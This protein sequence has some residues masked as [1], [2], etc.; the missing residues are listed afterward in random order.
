MSR[1]E[2]I[3]IQ[4][5][6]IADMNLVEHRDRLLTDHVMVDRLTGRPL[7]RGQLFDLHA[8]HLVVLDERGAL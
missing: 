1:D 2:S 8:I 5:Q 3:A 7:N 6:I 4:R